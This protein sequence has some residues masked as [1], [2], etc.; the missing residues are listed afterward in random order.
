MSNLVVYA[1]QISQRQV[2]AYV[3]WVIYGV[4]SLVSIQYNISIQHF[5]TFFFHC[6]HTL[7]NIW[8]VLNMSRFLGR[9]QNLTRP[10]F[11]LARLWQ[12]VENRDFGYNIFTEAGVSLEASYRRSTAAYVA[13]H[14]R[15]LNLTF[16]RVVVVIS[17][18]ETTMS[19][20]TSYF[21]SQ[22]Y[23]CLLITYGLLLQNSMK[24]LQK[25][26]KM[27]FWGSHDFRV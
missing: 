12:A 26:L 21:N 8:Q 24:P 5:E 9:C 16:K 10:M 20:C 4:S 17:S 3:F 25:Y 23:S 11:Q 1:V 27:Y 14:C 6:H 13:S 15:L 19:L 2:V 22:L 7:S 18:T